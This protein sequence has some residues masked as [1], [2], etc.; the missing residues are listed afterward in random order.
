M[1]KYKIGISIIFMALI[2]GA[3]IIANK[4]RKE[5]EPERED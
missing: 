1:D 5:N 4:I 3:M 2:L